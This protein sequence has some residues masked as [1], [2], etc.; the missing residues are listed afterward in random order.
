M[1][2]APSKDD[3]NAENCHRCTALCGIA[4]GG[5]GSAVHRSRCRAHAAPRPGHADLIV[6]LQDDGNGRVL[7]R[8]SYIQDKPAQ[9]TIAAIS[10]QLLRRPT[11]VLPWCCRLRL[12]PR[13]A[14]AAA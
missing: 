6:Y 9:R 4:L 1:E 5:R 11:I 2:A 7:A 10:E 8:R 13:P 14:P 3:I 12:F